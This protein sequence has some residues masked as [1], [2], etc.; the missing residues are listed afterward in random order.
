M[1][2]GLIALNGILGRK[3]DV[4]SHLRRYSEHLD[5][6]WVIG[7]DGGISFLR[8]LDISPS[9]LLGDFDSVSGLEEYLELWPDV[10]CDKFPSEKDETDAELAMDQMLEK[11][12]DEV[13]II[14]GFGGRLDHLMANVFLLDRV[15][16]IRAYMIDD[17]NCLQ[18][19]KG[20]YETTIWKDTLFGKYIS[21]VPLDAHIEGVDLRGFKYP[22]SNAKIDF[23]ETIGISNELMGDKGTVSL[24]SGKA[25]LIQSKDRA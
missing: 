2:I 1:K 6:E 20:P 19:I 14:G 4:E 3:E 5:F 8:E 12:V 17:I 15:K 16:S 22:L 10:V 24:K 7:V 11:G 23:S 25:L 13:L 18:I 21:I 9:Q